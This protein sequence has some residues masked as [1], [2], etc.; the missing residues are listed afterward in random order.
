MIKPLFTILLFL[1]AAPLWAAQTPDAG[2]TVKSVEHLLQVIHADNSAKQLQLQVQAAMDQRMQQ[3][4]A[5]VADKAVVDK[6]SKEFSTVVLPELAWSK[7][8]PDMVKAYTT[9]FTEE[10]VLGLV[11]FYTSKTGQSYLKKAPTLDR[12]T[13]ATTQ[14]RLQALQPKLQD[15]SRRMDA[16]LQAQRKAQTP[17]APKK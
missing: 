15:I 16:E 7:L 2:A 1:T 9:T 8:E 17:P 13:L 10:E 5:G 14:T 3:M 11:Q 4:N 6:Y 12:L